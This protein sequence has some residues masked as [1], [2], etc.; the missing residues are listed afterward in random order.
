[1]LVLLE[2]ITTVTD[3][4]K[5]VLEPYLVSVFGSIE[6]AE[7]QAHKYVLEEWPPRVELD[8]VVYDPK[9]HMIRFTQ[10]F[11]LRPKSTEE[12]EAEKSAEGNSDKTP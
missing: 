7:A 12:L 9:S 4:Y 6:E 8:D 2:T 11:K 3:H 1:M 10:T 5:Q